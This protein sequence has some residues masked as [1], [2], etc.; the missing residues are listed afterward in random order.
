MKFIRQIFTPVVVGMTALVNLPAATQAA[1]LDF[2]LQFETQN[3]SVWDSGNSL[4]FTDNRFIG[5]DWNESVNV[6]RTI[7]GFCIIPNLFGG[8]A[9]RA[10]RTNVGLNASTNG[11]IGLQSILNVN[12][13]S[14]NALIPVDLSF[15]I[16]DNPVKPGEM[17]T[18][19]SAYSFNNGATFNTSSPNASYNLDFIFDVAAN[20]DVNPGSFLD[21]GFDFDETINLV[22]FNSANL[23]I[24]TSNSFGS[25]Q[26]DFPDVKTVGTLTAPSSNQLT[27]SGQDEF[28]KGTLD[29]DSIAT[30]LL[31]LPPLEDEESIGL[32]P[33][34][35]L[36]FNYN[37]LDIEGR[38]GLS[39]LQQFTLTGT[40]P[41]LLSV[42]G[43]TPISFNIGEAIDI[44]VPDEVGN[45]L[46]IKAGIDF[47]GL[48]SN[49]TSLGLD[50]DLDVL[51]AQFGLEIPLID[52]VTVGPLVDESVDL[53]GTSF[54]VFS[55]T[56]PLGGF[57]SQMVSFTIP[58]ASGSGNGGNP[59]NGNTS[60]P[61][62]SSAVALLGFSL[63]GL[64][65]MNRR[66]HQLKA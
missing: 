53:F 35:S 22:S 37:L 59:G 6:G 19:Q 16:P 34:G 44:T 4:G 20:V 18:I 14:V 58:T 17:F 13:G 45:F 8:C 60:I 25:L 10:P 42:N 3:Q 65:F 61:E 47:D 31:G 49:A 21:F 28:V 54:E 52:D 57:N 50:F 5:V 43:G 33:L 15:V 46:D 40:L 62:P 41:A 23:S 36:G 24:D 55:N 66:K 9:V 11:E 2:D 26:V 56:F 7:G 64:G 1:T 48:F 29:L 27:S 30:S 32:G 51:A 38:A 39:I 12:G 63:V